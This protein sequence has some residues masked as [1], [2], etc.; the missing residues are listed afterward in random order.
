MPASS[1]YT[2]IAKITANGTS[3]NMSFSSIPQLY[4]DLVVVVNANTT[5][6]S[7]G[8]IIFNFASSG[9]Y[10]GTVISGNGSGVATSARVT[11]SGAGPMFLGSGN[12]QT[13]SIPVTMV[14]NINNYTNTNIFK[15]YIA[16]TGSDLNGSGVTQE[17]VGLWQKT[18][19]I[20]EII[21]STGSASIYW[22]GSATLYGIKAA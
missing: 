18:E 14:F 4:T 11:S 13:S 3:P 5:G 2:P 9:T 22:T 21:F 20:N 7:S 15:S 17:V 8:N 12:F 16:R 1:T 19:S 6:S 10:S